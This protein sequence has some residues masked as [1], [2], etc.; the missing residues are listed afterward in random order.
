MIKGAY[1]PLVKN[2]RF[3]AHGLVHEGK[4]AGY[5]V[6]IRIPL[7]QTAL[8]C[9]LLEEV[10]PYGGEPLLHVDPRFFAQTTLCVYCWRRERQAMAVVLPQIIPLAQ[11]APT[12]VLL[13]EVYTFGDETETTRGLPCIFA[14]T[15]PSVYCWERAKKLKAIVLPFPT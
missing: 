6:S 2:G 14:Q 1:R 11:T 4:E 12:C 9:V 15:T 3:P 10:G 5:M 7:A 13:E 8:R